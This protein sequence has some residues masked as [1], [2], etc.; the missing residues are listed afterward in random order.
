M[1]LLLSGYPICTFGFSFFDFTGRRFAS[2]FSELVKKDKSIVFKEEIQYS[3]VS[4]SKF[5]YAIIKMLRDVLAKTS[6]VIF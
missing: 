3:I 1:C 6:S 2:L 4:R 5:S